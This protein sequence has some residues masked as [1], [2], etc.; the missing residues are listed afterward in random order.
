LEVEFDGA[1]S[2]TA[3]GITRCGL[4]RWACVWHSVCS[5]L[6]KTS[7]NLIQKRL[8]LRCQQSVIVRD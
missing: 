6:P 4:R 5:S 3:P 2:A 1:E 7:N 8:D